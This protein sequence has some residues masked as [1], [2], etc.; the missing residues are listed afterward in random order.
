[1]QTFDTSLKQSQNE[2]S[3]ILKVDDDLKP[4]KQTTEVR[5]L[6]IGNVCRYINNATGCRKIYKTDGI[7][8]FCYSSHFV[9]SGKI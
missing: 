6:F 4:A 8:L 9:P 1:M 7:L 5:Q 2:T 3:N